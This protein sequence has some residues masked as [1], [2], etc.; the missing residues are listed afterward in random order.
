MIGRS[1]G[2]I[3]EAAWWLHGRRKF[4]E[5]ADIARNSKRRAHGK[6][7]AFVALMALAAVQ[8][9]DTLFEI[10]RGINGQSPAERL[11]VRQLASAPLVAELEIWMRAERAKLSRHNDV[12]KAIDYMLNR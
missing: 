2:P 3:I 12:A 8:R 4:F 10:E 1:A 9:I 11:A 6:A 7:P 5:L